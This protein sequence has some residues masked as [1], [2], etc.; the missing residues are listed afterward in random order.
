MCFLIDDLLD[1]T[2]RGD[3]RQQNM[4][5]AAQTPSANE[6]GAWGARARTGIERGYCI[7]NH[8]DGDKDEPAAMAK[9]CAIDMTSSSIRP[10]VASFVPLP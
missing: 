5:L 4:F 9:L 1:A 6:S 7:R 10:N 8:L 2:G 3:R